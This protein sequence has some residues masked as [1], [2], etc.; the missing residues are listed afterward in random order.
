MKRFQNC[1][2]FTASASGENGENAQKLIRNL[3]TE[4]KFN[5]VK[6]D[7]VTLKYVEKENE[8]GCFV[9]GT[10]NPIH[11][12]EQRIRLL[13]KTSVLNIETVR[14]ILKLPKE[15]AKKEKDHFGRW[16]EFFHIYSHYYPRS[17]LECKYTINK[18][19]NTKNYIFAQTKDQALLVRVIFSLFGYRLT[20]FSEN[21]KIGETYD[22]PIH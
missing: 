22:I 8:I 16:E 2:I 1:C 11:D 14:T 17:T 13:D 10:D 21:M 7:L 9:L 12:I 19:K 15:S 20:F 18:K 5:R 6:L 4:L 3:C